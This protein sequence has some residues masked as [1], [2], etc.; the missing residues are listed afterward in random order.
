MEVIGED[1]RIYDIDDDDDDD[2]EGDVMGDLMGYAGPMGDYEGDAS[3]EIDYDD[4][5][6]PII[7]GR[8]RRRRRRRHHKGRRVVRVRKPGWRQSQLAPGVI[9]PDQGLLVLPM[10]GVG[11]QEFT[12]L[13]NTITFQ[14]QVQKPFR[15][16]R[17]LVSTVRTGT[18]AVGRL[19]AQLF[20]GTDMQQLDVPQ[21]DAEQ[22]GDPNAFGVRM[23]MKPCQPGVFIRLVV[24]LS[25]A[26]VDQDK[27]AAY[28]TLMGR[29]LH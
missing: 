17:L 19:L 25:A 10:A 20:V 29:N 23:A 5:G 24:T 15:G 7:V 12:A 28:V 1:G 6:N 14:G 18:S 22:V 3:A 27:I 9:A 11:G 21:F 4:E 16:E 13:I 26:L 8:G 2:I